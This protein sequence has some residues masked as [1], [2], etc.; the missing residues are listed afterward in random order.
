MPAAAAAVAADAVGITAT[1]A[2]VDLSADSGG[3]QNDGC[4]D[5]GTCWVGRELL[6]TVS[7]ICMSH[8]PH[9]EAGRR[10]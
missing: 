9:A 2:A 10:D 4:W 7:E 8:Y 6:G 3:G 1:D 5:I